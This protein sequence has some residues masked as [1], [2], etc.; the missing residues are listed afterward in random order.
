L[1]AGKILWSRGESKLVARRRIASSGRISGLWRGLVDL[2][3]PPL[4]AGC[5]APIPAAG[6]NAYQEPSAFCR[7]CHQRL[8]WLSA[9]GC[10]LCGGPPVAAVGAVD[11]SRV[12]ESGCESAPTSKDTSLCARC[13][14]GPRSRLLACVAA[15]AFEA[16]ALRWIYRMK[17][18]SQGLAGLDPAARVVL[19]AF[20]RAAAERVQGPA[21]EWIVPVPLHP[22]RLRERGFNPAALI[23]REL[24]RATGARC[25]PRALLRVRDTSSQTGLG[26]DAR[27]RNVAGAFIARPAA[28]PVR[29]DSASIWLVDDVVTTRSTLVASAQPLRELGAGQITAV[30]LAQ[31]PE[32]APSR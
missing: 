28:C 19:R 12:P 2:A 5:R 20:A 24:A 32:A 30:C 18:P 8:P 3:L 4:C 11:R 23:A 29:P 15:L 22:R 7:A 13:A 31:T 26:R 14:A 25:A 16:E 17:Y 27:R 9:S 6:S 1:A 10:R 21:P